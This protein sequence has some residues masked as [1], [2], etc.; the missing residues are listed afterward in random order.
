MKNSEAT[1]PQTIET[2]ARIRS[3][4]RM[5]QSM[6]FQQKEVLVSDLKHEIDRTRDCLSWPFENVGKPFAAY[7]DRVTAFDRLPD[8][9]DSVTSAH[10]GQQRS[11]LVESYPEPPQCCSDLEYRSHLLEA[12]LNLTR[13]E[14]AWKQGHPEEA[15]FFISEAKNCL[16]RA[17]GYYQVMADQNIKTSRATRGGHQK[18]QNA[19][20]KEQQLY[21]QLL[22]DLAPFD[23]W[24]SESEAVE[25]IS[26][27]AIG[28]LETF[29]IAAG[30]TYAKLSEMLGSDSNVRA[31]FE[32]KQKR[33]R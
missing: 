28:I 19:K 14:D 29:G 33:A 24:K 9:I 22:K 15:W 10:M 6:C 18:A 32:K 27:I 12:C 8:P 1:S 7:L 17:D 4:Q 31:V 20:D 16:G 30:D 11:A 25:K 21:I 23:G 2:I 13:G 3:S 5:K 26:S